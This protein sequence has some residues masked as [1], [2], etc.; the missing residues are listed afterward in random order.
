M[1]EYAKLVSGGYRATRQASEAYA[2]AI[3][4]ETANNMMS[5]TTD[6]S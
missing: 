5:N 1:T 6:L 2:M 4:P 3:T